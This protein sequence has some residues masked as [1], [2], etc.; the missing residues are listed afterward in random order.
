MKDVL[1]SIYSI[2]NGGPLEIHSIFPGYLY[3][4]ILAFPSLTR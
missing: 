2:E 4:K 3:G 1:N